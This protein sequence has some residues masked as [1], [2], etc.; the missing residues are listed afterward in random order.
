M[1]YYSLK[2]WM[3]RLMVHCMVRSESD[4]NDSV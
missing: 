3:F 2:T 1:L 4:M